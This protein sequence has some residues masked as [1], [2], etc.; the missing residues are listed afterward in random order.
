M[1][2]QTLTDEQLSLVMSAFH[3][4]IAKANMKEPGFALEAMR[5]ALMI[6]ADEGHGT[7]TDRALWVALGGG[8]GSTASMVNQLIARLD[9]LQA[10]AAKVVTH[11]KWVLK[12]DD[13]YG[14]PDEVLAMV[15]AEDGEPVRKAYAELKEKHQALIEEN[16][17]I[18]QQAGGM[19][20]TIDE[21]Q[22]IERFTMYS[23]MRAAEAGN[24]VLTSNSAHRLA[25]ALNE[26]HGKP[27]DDMINLND[28]ITFIPNER[29]RAWAESVGRS[30]LPKAG[31][32]HTMLI[33]EF[34][35]YFGGQLFNGMIP[36]WDDCNFKLKRNT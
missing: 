4:A 1:N 28:S 2:P 11:N 3:G 5:T 6:I 16:A 36:F 15:D 33:W 31:E 24:V 14:L 35:N 27:I 7:D 13:H 23:V 12:D 17:A 20:M 10:F 9:N 18:R 26:Q 22:S 34:A 29:G 25:C 19:Q 32:P 8:L 30:D 21:L